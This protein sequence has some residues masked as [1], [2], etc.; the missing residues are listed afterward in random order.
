[1]TVTNRRFCKQHASLQMFSLLQCLCAMVVWTVSFFQGKSP[2]QQLGELHQR[3][4]DLIA[5]L[6]KSKN[7]AEGSVSP[8]P[9]PPVAEVKP[10]CAVSD[11]MDQHYAAALSK[12]VAD[13]LA[14]ALCT[15]SVATP[16]V[17]PPHK[18][19]LHLQVQAQ[20]EGE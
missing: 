4:S 9:S 1:M 6:T 17:A 7:S 10:R 20:T 15:M 14:T 19:K 3:R 18:G 13:T 8:Q 11:R 2:S 16:Q 12:S 5:Q